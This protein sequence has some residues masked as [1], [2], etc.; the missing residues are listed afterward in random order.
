MP[1]GDGRADVVRVVEGVSGTVADAARVDRAVRLRQGPAVGDPAASDEE[2][3]EVISAIAGPDML[4]LRGTRLPKATDGKHADTFEVSEGDE[5]TFIDHLVQVAPADPADARRRA[6]G[7]SDTIA[8]S[9]RLGGAAAA[10]TARTHGAVLRSLLVLRMLTHGGTG[11]HR[12]R[13]D[14][15]AARGLRR[16]SATGTT[17][18]AGCATP[19]SP[20]RRCCRPATTGRPGSGATGCCAR[21]P[22]TRRTCRSCTPSTG[23]ATCPS[24]SST[25]SPG[26]PTRGRSGSAT[27]PS[28]RR[29]TDVFGEVLRLAGAGPSARAAGDPALVGAAALRSAKRAARSTGTSPTTDCG[30]SVDRSSTSR[31]RG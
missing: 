9:E 8:L 23:R 13:A 16:R 24:A 19:R 3:R 25:T 2:G 4:V 31:T 30:R 22:E 27:A 14:H 15:L 10:T 26:T 1:I 6:S 21:S 20:W 5:L 17:A 11:G 29:Q 18:T 7:S 28:T 12:R